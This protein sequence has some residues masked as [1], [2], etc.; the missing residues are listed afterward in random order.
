[1]IILVP[2][3]CRARC[4]DCCYRAIQISI[5]IIITIIINSDSCG[6]DPEGS[7]GMSDVS[8]WCGISGLSFDST[9]RS[10]RLFFCLL[11]LLFLSNFFSFCL[12]A[13]SPAFFYRK[14]L[15]KWGIVTLATKYV[16]ITT[17]FKDLPSNNSHIT[18]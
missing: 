16:T 1:M 8:P 13:H 14:L 7:P 4:T 18:L 15:I 2:S 6:A 5:A 3:Y 11:P 17:I 12:L 10:G 9:L